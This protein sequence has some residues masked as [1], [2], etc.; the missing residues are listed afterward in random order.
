MVRAAS[1]FILA[2]SLLA[3]TAGCAQAA[4]AVRSPSQLVKELEV[5]PPCCVVDARSDDSQRR[6]PLA[7][8]VRYRPGLRI[9]PAGPVV[10]LGDQERG[11]LKAAS[12]LARQHPGTEI[13]ALAGGAAAWES[14]RRKLEA[15][16]LSKRTDGAAPAI[17]FVIPHNTCETGAPLQILQSKPRA[18]P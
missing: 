1:R 15:P 2:A 9:V 11:A 8:V 7:D 4:V 10:V 14:V 3:G 16:R 13:Y 5:R 17:T 6:H 12:A 18:K